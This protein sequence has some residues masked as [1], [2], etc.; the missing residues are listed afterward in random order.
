ME[1]RLDGPLSHPHDLSDLADRPVAYIEQRH[2]SA[3]TIRQ[4]CHRSPEVAVE[5]QRG[6]DGT[7]LGLAR[8]SG[9]ASSLHFAM[10]S[11]V[12]RKIDH[13]APRPHVPGWSRSP[14]LS[15]ELKARARAS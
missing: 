3:L 6:G 10:A 8:Q 7:H 1:R 12:P 4:R 5:R 2:S 15:H 11:V 14:T 9:Q 13:D